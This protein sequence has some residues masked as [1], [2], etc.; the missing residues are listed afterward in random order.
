MVDCRMLQGPL[1]GQIVSIAAEDA[2]QGVTDN[3]AVPVSSFPSYPWPFDVDRAEL[4]SPPPP[5]FD[6]WVEAG[7]PPGVPHGP[8][9]PLPPPTISAIDPTSALMGSTPMTITITGTGF[10]P[11]AQAVAVGTAFPEDIQ[12]PTQY[13]SPTQLTATLPPEAEV[14]A[15][16]DGFMV[17]VAQGGQTGGDEMF[18]FTA[19]PPID[20]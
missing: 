18:I 10:I 14:G 3:W 7:S 11:G 12:L 2:A 8:P 5:S 1:V 4:A 19:P 17:H 6:E 15:P 13:D 16:V 9:Q 20:G